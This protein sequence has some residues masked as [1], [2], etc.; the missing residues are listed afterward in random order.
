MEIIDRYHPLLTSMALALLPRNIVKDVCTED[1]M[2]DPKL[3]VRNTNRFYTFR[4][5]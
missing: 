2:M 4:I 1:V 5:D 3:P